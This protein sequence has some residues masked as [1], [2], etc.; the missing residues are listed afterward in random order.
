MVRSKT[1]RNKVYKYVH[2]KDVYIKTNITGLTF[3][4]QWLSIKPD[5]RITVK[6]NENRGYAWDGCSPKVNFIHLIWGTPDG[7]LDFRTEKPMTYYASMI[8]DALYQYKKSVGMSRRDA[9]IIFEEIL[10]ESKFMWWWLYGLAVK[11]GGGFYGKWRV[12]ENQQTKIEILDCSWLPTE[13]EIAKQDLDTATINSRSE[14]VDHPK[15]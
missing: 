9:D 14:L 7:Q 3:D 1:I 11:V 5:G 15:R 10:K 2:E 13:E 12:T 8:H 6:G 4:N